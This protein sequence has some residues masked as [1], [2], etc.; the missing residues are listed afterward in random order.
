MNQILTH[1]LN[2]HSVEWIAARLNMTSDQVVESIRKN[3]GVL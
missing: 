3:W 2:G 1:W